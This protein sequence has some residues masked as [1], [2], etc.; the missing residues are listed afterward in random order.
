MVAHG[1]QKLDCVHRSG[2][3]I[4]KISRQCV[5]HG[6]IPSGETTPGI[7]DAFS[8]KGGNNFIAWADPAKSEG[9]LNV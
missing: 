5:A 9:R 4:L 8:L 2:H 6:G 3:M 1:L 7:L